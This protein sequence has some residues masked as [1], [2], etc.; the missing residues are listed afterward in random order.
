[1]TDYP[2]LTVDRHVEENQTVEIELVVAWLF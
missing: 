1:V 2:P